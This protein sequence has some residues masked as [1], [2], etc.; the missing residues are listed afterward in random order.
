MGRRNGSRNRGYFFR[1]GRGW[2]T[3]KD[4]RFVALE[5]ENG[6]RMRDKNTPLA[7]VKAAHRRVMTSTEESVDSDAPTVLEVCTEYLNKVKDED[8]E[9][10]YESR[11][12]TLFDFCLGL[13]PRFRTNGEKPEKSDY[14]HKGYGNL[15][16]DKLTKLHVKHWLQ[17]HPTWNGGRRSKI[18]AVKR[19]R[20]YAVENDFLEAN[21]IKG[22]ATPKQNARVTYITPEQELALCEAAKPALAIAIKVCIRTGARPGC[23]FA[24]LTA[25]HV[26]DHGDRMEWTF[27]P[28]ES[29]TKNLRVIR[30]TDS[31]IIDIVRQRLSY[32]GPIFRNISGKPWTR[33]NLGERFRFV[34]NRLA[35]QG[36]KFD[37]DCVM[38]SCRHTYAKRILQGYWS[39]KPTNIETLAKL[40][41]NTPEV[42]RD[43]YLRWCDHYLE[44]LW[45]SA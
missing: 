32:D 35:K 42:C 19:A 36:V 30:I 33:E 15:P 24:A 37:N 21:P 3:K 22:F 23:E 25:N 43:H 11:V 45:E 18:Q 17:A 38:Y 28:N 1:E 13:P 2:C 26:T 20:N 31:E 4:G 12:A 6:D 40:M 10:T 14:I 8:A 41:G 7:D 44:P 34:R 29:K 27:Q 39:D 5:Y 9:A 16:S